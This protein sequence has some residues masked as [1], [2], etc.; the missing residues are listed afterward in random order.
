MTTSTANTPSN[1]QGASLLTGTTPPASQPISTPEAGELERKRLAKSSRKHLHRGYSSED[2]L[3]AGEL[4]REQLAKSSRERLHR[5]Y[6]SEDKLD[7][8]ELG[9]ERLAKSSREHLQRG[10]S[11]GNERD[12]SQGQT[13]EILD[14][15]IKELDRQEKERETR[16]ER[17]GQRKPDND[18]NNSGKTSSA[19]EESETEG[20]DD[21][22]AAHQAA[23]IQEDAHWAHLLGEAPLH[24]PVHLP[25]NSHW[26]KPQDTPLE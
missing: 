14:R 11:S 22:P 21:P 15:V 19:G 8:G 24:L 6:S 5:G 18:V 1:Q 2:E 4:Q 12:L 10:Y 13:R 26:C 7:A 17:D 25:H 16:E 20:H 9:R 23:S 3:E